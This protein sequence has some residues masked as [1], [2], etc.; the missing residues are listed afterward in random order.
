M[1][2]GLLV[3]IKRNHWIIIGVKRWLEVGVHL[4]GMMLSKYF[5][6]KPEIQELIY[7]VTFPLKG[8]ICKEDQQ[9]V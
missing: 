6:V 3:P 1:V 4:S 8:V 7:G 5:K 9:E 2:Q